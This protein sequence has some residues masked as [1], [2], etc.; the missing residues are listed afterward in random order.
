MLEMNVRVKPFAKGASFKD[1]RARIVKQLGGI[2]GKA[3]Q[4]V[5]ETTRTLMRAPKSGIH[6]PGLPNRSSAKG[7]APATQSGKLE[8]SFRIQAFGKDRLKRRIGTSLWYGNYLMT[9][10]ERPALAPALRK[11]FPAYIREIEAMIG[12]EV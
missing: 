6:H 8:R 7:E 12:R 5:R 11:E 10:K 4:N 9:K 1:A 2:T 3:A